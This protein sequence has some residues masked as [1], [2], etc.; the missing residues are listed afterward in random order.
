MPQADR[1]P[2]SSPGICTW[3]ADAT[4]T[5]TVIN[6][7]W[8]YNISADT[9]TAKSNMPVATNVPGSAAALGTLRVFGSG[10]PFGPSLSLQP[11][12]DTAN[13]GLVYDPVADLW[14][15]DANLNVAR[16]F[17]AGSWVPGAGKLVA[18]GGYDGATTR[19]TTEVR[20]L[21]CATPTPT[22]T[23]PPP[24][25]TPTPTP[26]ACV[27]PCTIPPPPAPVVVTN[28]AA[29]PVT[30]SSS[31]TQINLPGSDVVL[32]CAL[33]QLPGTTGTRI[34]A[35]SILVDGP[36][37]GS[38]TSTGTNGTQL[39]AG[40]GSGQCNAGATVDV[41][42]SSV[43]AS[44]ANGGLK[45]TGCG[46]IVLNS[47]TINSGGENSTT[48]SSG[49]RICATNDVM[50]GGSASL[51][52]NGDLTMHGTTVTVSPSA[53]D[54]IK[55]TSV[56]GSVLA[57]GGVCLP[58]RFTGG[59]DSNMTVTASGIVDLS[60]ACVEIAQ[61]ITVTAGGTGFV[62]ATDAIINVGNAEI[63]NDFGKTGVITMTACGGAG[64]IEIGNAIL[65][66]SGKSGGG[67]D[68]D[69]VSNLNG[70]LATQPV[71]C[72]SST[73]PTCTARPLDAAHNP[74]SADPANRACPQ[75]DRRREVRHVVSASVGFLTR[76]T[77][78]SPAFFGALPPSGLLY[79]PPVLSTSF[80]SSL[81]PS[82]LLVP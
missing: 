54:T 63:R 31:W 39:I 10:N 53:S 65:V 57:G 29:P 82:G 8:D 6:L 15:N 64:R 68:P 21:Q 80:R 48:L 20:T 52:S 13:T 41:E 76:G 27:S 40:S 33:N 17:V 24:T 7:T 3:P 43:T 81:R 30:T 22:N 51:T 72:A 16:S 23:P 67:D 45:I 62:C 69:K 49:G 55:L 42:S 36:N 2:V 1:H 32:Q 38:V 25:N 19:N 4:P 47:S 5:N 18:A 35:H 75:R 11:G 28:C 60:Y 58:N 56:N 78:R 71:N 79:L 61:S 50:S 37:G 12:P 34:L 74:V 73:S 77:S 44:N 9:W 70:S 14:S 46:D 26:P 59:N 66:D